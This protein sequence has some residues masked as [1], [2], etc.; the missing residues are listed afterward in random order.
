MSLG[1]LPRE[2]PFVR[3]EAVAAVSAEYGDRLAAID[4]IA[5]RLGEFYKSRPDTDRDLVSRAIASAQDVWA[6]NVFPPMR[7]KFGTY[8]NNL[9]HVD[10]PGCFRC[11][12]DTHKSANGKVISQD[13]E[14]CH[15]IQ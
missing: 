10:S 5:S 12:D 1:S 8:A 9:G 3:R 15:S 2:L 13:C 6:R 4:A 11:H 14:L 7:V